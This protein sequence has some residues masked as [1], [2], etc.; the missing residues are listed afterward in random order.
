M[1]GDARN[2]TYRCIAIS[3]SFGYFFFFNLSHFSYFVRNRRSSMR[4]FYNC[5][6]IQRNVLLTIPLCLN[7]GRLSALSSFSHKN[8]T[9][10]TARKFCRLFTWSVLERKKRTLFQLFAQPLANKRHIRHQT[11]TQ[12]ISSY[13]QLNTYNSPSILAT[14]SKYFLSVKNATPT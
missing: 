6:L 13:I 8:Y 1:F 5:Y 10:F 9:L 4:H 3:V 11:H 2:G 12:C 14:K 7:G